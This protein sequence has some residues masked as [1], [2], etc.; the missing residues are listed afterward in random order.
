MELHG[1]GIKDL[2]TGESESIHVGRLPGRKSVALY[3]LNGS[4]LDVLAYFKS[5]T[6]AERALDILDRLIKIS[7][8]GE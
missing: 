8:D 6:A 5:Q 1:W 3:A 2:L 4:V 7:K